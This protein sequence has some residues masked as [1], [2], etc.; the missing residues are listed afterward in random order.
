MKYSDALRAIECTLA[1]YKENYMLLYPDM[2]RTQYDG[3]ETFV[4]SAPCLKDEWYELLRDKFCIND[5]TRLP[6][7]V[8]GKKEEM[9][10]VILCRPESTDD[11]AVETAA[12]IRVTASKFNGMIYAMKY[13]D[14]P[15]FGSVASIIARTAGADPKQVK[16]ID[17]EPKEST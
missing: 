13:V 5:G 4:F 7:V 2:S 17:L 10:C 9:V 16:H 15:Q 12:W 1:A 8:H 6:Y 14:A 3:S 11:E